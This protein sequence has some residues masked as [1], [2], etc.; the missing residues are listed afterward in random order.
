MSDYRRS[1]LRG[2]SPHQQ[3]TGRMTVVVRTRPIACSLLRNKWQSTVRCRTQ[4]AEETSYLELLFGRDQNEPTLH[5]GLVLSLS[6]RTTL[7]Q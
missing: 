3:Q 7:N 2:N 6:V 4:M 1:D 5:V